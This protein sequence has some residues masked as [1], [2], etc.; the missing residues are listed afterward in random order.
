MATSKK[1]C[2]PTFIGIKFC[3]EC[4][5]MLYPKE[6]VANKRLVY[7][8]R[9]CGYDEIAKNNCVY[10]NNLDQNVNELSY[11]NTDIIQDPTLPRSYTQICP[12]CK[13][14]ETVFFQSD[15]HKTTEHGMKLYYVCTNPD[16]CHRWTQ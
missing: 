9:N 4:N 2:G 13:H 3:K 5:N 1:E 10:V 11:I 14:R 6:D 12:K 15:I 8:C 16:C 7:A